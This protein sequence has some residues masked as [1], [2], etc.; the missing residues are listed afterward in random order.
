[1]THIKKVDK[2]EQNFP[3]KTIEDV[4]QLF[5]RELEHEDGE[6]N[7]TLLSLVVGMI[8]N[9]LASDQSKTNS[10]LS[11]LMTSTICAKNSN[12]CLPLSRIIMQIRQQRMLMPVKRRANMQ[13][14]K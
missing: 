8:E 7:L 11:N 14:E 5:K 9:F 2:I 3:I 1:M 6:P 13:H 12:S 10:R 4:V